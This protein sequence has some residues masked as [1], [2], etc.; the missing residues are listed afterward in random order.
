MGISSY[1]PQPLQSNL[2]FTWDSPTAYN[3]QYY[4]R[5]RPR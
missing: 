3:G 4:I 1:Q 5:Y 2:R